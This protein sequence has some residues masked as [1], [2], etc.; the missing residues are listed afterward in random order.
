MSAKSAKRLINWHTGWLG[1]KDSNGDLVGDWAQ[2]FDKEQFKCRYCDV[3]RKYSNGGRTSLIQHSDSAKHKKIADGK[4]GRVTGQP[5]L[6]LNYCE[7]QKHVKQRYWWMNLICFIFSM[8]IIH[9]VL[10]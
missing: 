2:F 7:L 10:M 1:E 5:R 4:K 3:V 8:N 6:N 9:S